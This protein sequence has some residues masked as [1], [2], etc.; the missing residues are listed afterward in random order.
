MA[1]I[2]GEYAYLGRLRVEGTGERVRALRR[3]AECVEGFEGPLDCWCVA[4]GDGKFVD[5]WMYAYAGKN[6]TG[7]PEGFV[8]DAEG[9]EE[10]LAAFPADVAVGGMREFPRRG[11]WRLDANGEETDEKESAV[12][13]TVKVPPPDGHVAYKGAGD[14][15]PVEPVQ[16]RF[17]GG[18]RALFG[19]VGPWMVPKTGSMAWWRE[20]LEMSREEFAEYAGRVKELL[21][22][23]G[24][25]SGI[26]APHH[27]TE[28]TIQWTVVWP[29][30]GS[31]WRATAVCTRASLWV[32]G[33]V[34]ELSGGCIYEDEPVYIA[35]DV[36]GSRELVKGWTEKILRANGEDEP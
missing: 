21:F 19:L 32:G 27:E 34:L 30:G 10:E 24:M 13:G 4:A 9:F 12:L 2:S 23:Y 6:E 15:W 16:D 26:R 11:I 28:R 22:N 14:P 18:E 31:G 1:S 7:V 33:Q 17:V 29:V 36:D 35:G 20:G 8:L 5:V 3:G 25:R